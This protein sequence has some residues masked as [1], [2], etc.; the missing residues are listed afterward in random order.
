MVRN[1]GA[2]TG[3]ATVVSVSDDNWVSRQAALFWPKVVFAADDNDG[4]ISLGEKDQIKLDVRWASNTQLIVTYPEKARV[5]RHERNL[6]SIIIQ[7][8][9]LK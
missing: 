7:S 5:L 3:F 9:A 4:A 8:V 6:H 2:M 1:G